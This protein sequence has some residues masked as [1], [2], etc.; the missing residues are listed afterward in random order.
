MANICKNFMLTDTNTT[1]YYFGS[2]ELQETTGNYFPVWLRNRLVL[3]GPRGRRRK[4]VY[5]TMG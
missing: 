3:L 4:A 1:Y 2:Y 5:N